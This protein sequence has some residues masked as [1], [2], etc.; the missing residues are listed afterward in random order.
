[1]S[2]RSWGV[3]LEGLISLYSKYFVKLET[4]FSIIATRIL[5]LS[6]GSG[7]FRNFWAL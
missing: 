7:T 1:M 5:L 4:T 6:L 2:M 3:I